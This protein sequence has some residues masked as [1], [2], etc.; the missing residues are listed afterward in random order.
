[1]TRKRNDAHS[2]EFGL[3]LREQDFIS[4]AK[5]FVATNLDFIWCNYKQKFWMH[6]EEKRYNSKMSWAQE[7]QFKTLDLACKDYPH[8]RG[9]HLIVFE[10]TSPDDGKIFLNTKAISRSQLMKF[11]AFQQPEN[12]YKGYFH[13]K[14]N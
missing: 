1:M 8:Y 2:T 12:W 10:K 13:I 5:G 3:W 7:N 14:R 6:I 9:F 4:S 11:L